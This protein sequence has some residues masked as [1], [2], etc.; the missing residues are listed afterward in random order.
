MSENQ[1][2]ACDYFRRVAEWA[3]T[4]YGAAALDEMAASE[5]GV[6]KYARLYNAAFE[7]FFEKMAGNT[8]AKR[9]AVSL[10]T[11]KVYQEARA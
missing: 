3:A 1:K 5:E 8:G 4:E 2:K 7:A 6:A 10:L 11:A 9:R